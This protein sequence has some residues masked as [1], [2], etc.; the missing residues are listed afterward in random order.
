VSKPSPRGA[1]SKPKSKAQSSRTAAGRP[2]GAG[3]PAAVRPAGDRKPSQGRTDPC[4]GAAGPSGRSTEHRG[5]G[6]LPRARGTVAAGPVR[7]QKILADAGVASRRASERLI[8]EGAVTVNGKAVTELGA[9]ADPVVDEICVAGRRLAQPAAHKYLA[10]H[11]P[12]GYVTTASDEYGR[13]TV[14]DLL[15]DIGVR[16]FPIGRLDRETEGLLLLTNDG[17]LTE[18]LTHPRYGVEKEYYVEI[19]GAPTDAAIEQ[20][21]SGVTIEGKRTAPAQVERL[22]A[23][24]AEVWLRITI[25][26]GRKRQ[27]RLMCESIGLAV[28]RLIRVRVGPIELAE[29]PTG[30]YRHLS[31]REVTRLRRSVGL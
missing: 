22:S 20:L 6:G 14:L 26:E 1:T 5:P 15:P 30:R 17:G 3:Q 28:Q 25:H 23:D 16:V 19:E 10:L 29:L 12:A 24:D 31:P 4:F 8:L 2:G 7:L 18:R 9:R 21:R 27:I 11:K 13:A